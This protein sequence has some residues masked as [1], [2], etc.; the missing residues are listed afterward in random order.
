[1]VDVTVTFDLKYSL[2]LDMFSEHAIMF[3][4]GALALEAG[5]WQIADRYTMGRAELPIV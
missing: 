5:S 2:F 1:M 3:S 4:C